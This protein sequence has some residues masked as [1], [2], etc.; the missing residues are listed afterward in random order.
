MRAYRAAPRIAVA[1]VPV[2]PTS[3]SLL[4]RAHDF[5]ART[6]SR[7]TGVGGG[8][9]TASRIAAAGGSRGAGMAA[10]AKLL[11]ICAGAGSAAC[12]ATGVLPVPLVDHGRPPAPPIERAAEKPE[13]ETASEAVDYEPA[14]PQ[15]PRPDAKPERPP[16]EEAAATE[17]PST[18]A[19]EYES[20]SPVPA[21]AP[22]DGGESATPS[23]SAAGEFGP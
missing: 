11:A 21:P 1:L 20:P 15:G 14:P 17:S 13:R 19:V 16:R 2:L 5:L 3:R 12:V 22:S 10:L 18:G 8:T 9:D 7:L 4:E 6:G 23:G